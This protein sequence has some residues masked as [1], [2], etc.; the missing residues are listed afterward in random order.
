MCTGIRLITKNNAVVCA[1]T[2][3][4]AQNIESKIIGIPRNYSMVGTAP[5]GK[6][7]GLAWKTKYAAIGANA[8]GVSH[9][10]D[11]INEQGLAG[12]LFYFPD[13]AHYQ[14][15]TPAQFP[16]SLAPW[17]F[18]TW[19]LTSFSTVPQVKAALPTIKV[20]PVVFGPWGIIP[21][22]HAIIHDATG[23]SLVIEYVQG[24]LVMHDN[25]LGVITNAPTFDW[26]VT[27]LRNYINVSALN[28]PQVA[29]NSIKLDALGQGS[30]MLGLP[31]DFTSPSRFIRAVAFSQSVIETATETEALDTAFHVLNLFDISKGI[32]REQ[33]NNTIHYEYTQWTSASD[34]KNK[35][36]YFHTYDNRAVTMVDLTTMNLDAQEPT[37]TNM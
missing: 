32:V 7:E 34:L 22:T 35:R 3:E 28:V 4:F 33:Q 1:R 16:Q 25:A 29:L 26:H 10:L 21:P 5:S 30:G 18:L 36:Y 11:G 20:V 15:A 19:L 31:G 12:G 2:M 14:N 9:I 13:Y 23:Q 6:P 27:N 17:E 8:A 37:F 24:N